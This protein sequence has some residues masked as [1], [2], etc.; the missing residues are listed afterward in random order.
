M[1]PYLPPSFIFA[2][3]PNVG[4]ESMRHQAPCPP[5]ATISPLQRAAPQHTGGGRGG[6]GSENAEGS[7]PRSLPVRSV[8]GVDS[9]VTSS[10]EA[11]VTHKLHNRR[12]LRG[13][14][15]PARKFAYGGPSR[16]ARQSLPIL[17]RCSKL[18]NS[19]QNT[20]RCPVGAT[21]GTIPTITLNH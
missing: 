6:G 16:P 15:I 21:C 9:V 3:G 4:D 14:P 13:L 18:P 8:P 19:V 1:H 11:Y 10:P 12:Q 5:Q 7:E 2:L 17:A 20:Y